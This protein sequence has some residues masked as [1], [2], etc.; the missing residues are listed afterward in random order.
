MVLLPTARE[1]TGRDSQGK[2]MIPR[3]RKDRQMDR[4]MERQT[5]G[6]ILRKESESESHS[7]MSDSVTSWTI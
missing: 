2:L 1:N 5:D 4:Q 7:V 3:G 6:Y